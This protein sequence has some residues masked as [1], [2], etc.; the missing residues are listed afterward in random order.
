MNV[1]ISGYG[2]SSKICSILLQ[3][4]PF[5]VSVKIL[6][7]NSH[8]MDSS[9]MPMYTGLW[10]PAMKILNHIGILGAIKSKLMPV[11]SAGYKDASG[12]WLAL[13]NDGL[14]CDI[15]FDGERFTY[16]IIIIS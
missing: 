14:Q 12:N 5:V 13:P 1:I 9:D 4:L 15:N 2:L 7:N 3:R 16:C 11:S 10:T 6:Y 8:S